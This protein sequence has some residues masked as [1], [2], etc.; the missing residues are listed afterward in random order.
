MSAEIVA[1]CLGRADDTPVGDAVAVP[2]PWNRVE[3]VL[4]SATARRLDELAGGS[5]LLRL[6][7]LTGAVAVCLRSYSGEPAPRVCVSAIRDRT[8]ETIDGRVVEVAQTVNGRERI[9]DLLARTRRLLAAGSDADRPAIFADDVHPDDAGEGV[10]V[11]L[12]HSVE[13]LSDVRGHLLV[14]WRRMPQRHALIAEYRV[15]RF[16]RASVLRFARHMRSALDAV[17]HDPR[18]VVDDVCIVDLHERARLDRWSTGSSTRA[19]REPVHSLMMRQAA[20]RPRTTAIVGEDGELTY[21]EMRG[22]V[23]ATAAL[24]RT[25]GARR[26]TPVGVCLSRGVNLPP[27]LFGVL[28][29]GAAYVPLDPAEPDERLRFMLGEAGVAVVIS[30]ARDHDRLAALAPVSVLNVDDIPCDTPANAPAVFRPVADDLAYILFTSGSTGRPKGAMNTHGG[31]SNRLEWMQHAYR[32]KPRDVVLHKTPTTFDVSLWELV[33]PFMVGARLVVAKPDG[34]RD[35]AYLA[36]L[37]QEQSVTVAH[38]VPSMLRAF[39]DEPRSAACVSLRRIIC[40]GESLGWSLQRDC[41]SRLTGA[42]LSNLYGPTEAAIDVT[43]HECQGPGERRPVPIGRPIWNTSLVVLDRHGR[44]APVGSTGDLFIGGRNVALGY[45]GRP[46][47][48]AARFVP[49]PLPG[50]SGVRLYRTGDLARFDDDGELLFL[51]RRDHQVKVRGHRIELEEIDRVL[52]RHDDVAQVATVIRQA[53]PLGP[54]LIAFVRRRSSAASDTADLTAFAAARLPAYMVPGRIVAVDALPMTATGKVDRSALASRE[55]SDNSQP[56]DAP[57]Y[58][59]PVEEILADIWR[60]VLGIAIGRDDNVFERGAHS[61]AAA[62]AAARIRRVFAVDLPLQALFSAPTIRQLAL[63]ISGG[64]IAGADPSRVTGPRP[65]PRRD[66][67]PLSDAQR[68]LWFLEQTG[69]AGAA[70]HLPGAFRIRGPLSTGALEKSYDAVARRHEILQTVFAISD[71]IPVQRVA[72]PPPSILPVVDLAALPPAR[73]LDDAMSIS[74]ADVR[75]PFDFFRVPAWRC[76]LLRLADDDHV[77]VVCVHHIL[78]DAWSLDVWRRELLAVYRSLQ[79]TE[80][81]PLPDLPLQYAHYAAWQQEGEGWSAEDLEWWRRQLDGLEKVSLPRDRSATGARTG[82]GDVVSLELPAPVVAAAQTLAGRENAT[83][84][85]VLLAAFA[86]VLH[87]YGGACDIGIGVAVANRHRPEVESLIGLFANTLVL[88]AT[89]RDGDDFQQLLARVRDTMLDAFDRGHVPFERVVDALGVGRELSRNPLFDVMF[90]LRRSSRGAGAG[91]EPLGFDPIPLASGG[92]KFDLEVHAIEQG[93]GTWTVAAEYATDVFNRDTVVRL[94][95][96]Y[97]LLLSA[98]VEHPDLR[99]GELPIMEA[100]ERQQVVAIGR[101]V[102]VARQEDTLDG[103]IWRLA[104][105]RPSEIAAV[106]TARS[107]T[108]GALID[109]AEHLAG[110]LAA[111]GIGRED[112]VGICVD[113]SIDMV[114]AILAVLRAGACYVPLEPDTPAPRL[115]RIAAEASIGAVVTVRRYDHLLA[116][117]APAVRRLRLDETPGHAPVARVAT[118]SQGSLAYV[119]FTSGSTGVP[120]GAANEHGAVVNR[121]LWMQEC[122][123][124]DARDAVLHKTPLGF[125]VSGWEI[126]LPLIAGARLVIAPPGAHREPEALTELMT[127]YGVTVV[128]FVPSML[129]AWLQG[130]GPPRCRSLRLVIASGEGLRTSTI[131]EFRRQS[132]AELHNLYGPTEAAIDVTHWPCVERPATAV[133]PIGRPIANVGV[134]VVDSAL[135]LQP[136]GAHGEVC[137]GGVAP[138]R[139]YVGRPDLTAERFVPDSVSGASGAR[140]YRTGDIGRTTGSG[141]IEYLGRADAQVKVHGVR[142]E[143]PEIEAVMRTHPAVA[144]SAVVLSDIGGRQQLVA[145]V[146][147]RDAVSVGELRRH[148]ATMLPATMVPTWFVCIDALPVTANGK[149][150][151]RSLPQPTVESTPMRRLPETAAERTV[152]EIWR[153]VL[154]REAGVDDNF[155][156]VGGDSIQALRVIAKAAERGLVLTV[157]DLFQH[158]TIADLATVSAA[159]AAGGERDV[160]DSGPCELLAA[161]HWFFAQELQQPELFCQAIALEASRAVAPDTVERALAAVSRRHAALRMSFACGEDGWHAAIDERDVPVPLAIVDVSS[162]PTSAHRL[163]ATRVAHDLQRSIR[164]ERAPLWRVGLVRGAGRDRLIWVTHHTISDGVSLA[165]LVEDFARA[166]DSLESGGHPWR[167]APGVSIRA[168]AAAARRAVAELDVDAE[169]RSWAAAGFDRIA[170]LPREGAGGPNVAE[171]VRHHRLR[172]TD[173]QIDAVVSS[174]RHDRVDRREVV[175]AA[176]AA[177]IGRMFGIRV[178]GIDIE[179]H[180]RDALE[181]LDASRTVGWFTTVAPVVIDVS[182][183]DAALASVRGAFERGTA[184]ARFFLLRYL[185]PDAHVRARV[186]RLVAPDIVFNDL[187]RWGGPSPESRFAVDVDAIEPLR[188]NPNRR[189]HL[190]EITSFAIDGVVVVDL[191]YSVNT[192]TPETMDLVAAELQRSLT[193]LSGVGANVARHFPLA[194][195]S[196]ASIARV[197]ARIPFVE[198]IHPLTPVQEG[199]LFHSL[200]D[201]SREAYWGVVATLW[202]RADRGALRK[203]VEHVRGR[204]PALRSRIV[205]EDVERPHQV[206]VTPGAIAWEELDWRDRSAEDQAASM[207][208]LLDAPAAPGSDGRDAM[209]WILV[210]LGVDRFYLV[211]AHHHALVDG[212]SVAT[213]GR[214]LLAAYGALI[215]G[216][217]PALPPA[218]P[219]RDYV[220]WRADRDR[221]RG[222]RFWRRRLEGCRPTLLTAGRVPDEGEGHAEENLTLGADASTALAELARA[223]RVT[224]STLVSAAWALVLAASTRATD[225]VFGQTVSG[226]PAGLQGSPDIV[227]MFINTVPCRIGVALGADVRAWLRTIFAEHAEVKQFE[228]LPLAQIGRTTGVRPGALFDSILVVENYPVLPDQTVSD[229]VPVTPVS[230]RTPNHYPFTVRVEPGAVV[231][232][233][234][235]FARRWFTSREA[236]RLLSAVRTVLTMFV[237]PSPIRVEAVMDRVAPFI[238]DEQSSGG[239]RSIPALEAVRPTP[240]DARQ[241]VGEIRP[242]MAGSSFPLLVQPITP[243]VQPAEWMA[244]ERERLDGLLLERGALLFRGFPIRTLEDFERFA[245]AFSDRLY[246]Q[247]GDLPRKAMTMAVYES[248]AYPADRWILFHNES[249]HLASW[250]SRIWFFCVEAARQGGETPIADCRRLCRVIDSSIIE[251]VR[252]LGFQYVRN[253]VDKLDVSWQQFFHTTDRAIVEQQCR[254][255]GTSFEW[256]GDGGLRTVR[257]AR[258]ITT[259][260]RTG[261]ELFFAQVQLHHPSCLDPAVRESIAAV[262]GA[263]QFPRDV[264]FGDG[265]V[266]DDDTMRRI[267]EAYEQS[268]FAFPWQ[269]GDVLLL[270]NMLMAHARRPFVGPRSC[271]VVLSDVISDAAV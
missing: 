103:L 120:K 115:E 99:L 234:A 118:S 74:R 132:Q 208:A 178:L 41:L 204:H 85:A 33:W 73:R 230:I 128:H 50:A 269:A 199:M 214:E 270:D 112:R 164:L 22:R 93:D 157:H 114:A 5:R 187:G 168:W 65:L 193:A 13:R 11:A 249:S 264:R 15:G 36:E 192:H 250:P 265:S 6:S 113:R 127:T 189:T 142:I 210:Q 174:A 240:L 26:G 137:I 24:L 221:E 260:P 245:R 216:D 138:A 72:G 81:E 40:S 146:V 201:S 211:W 4:S 152:A 76:L 267:G 18:R 147:P 84:F 222:E 16:E 82:V 218:R 185:H 184:A 122:F 163:A 104:A 124:L 79:H 2:L 77:L 223:E 194:R 46:D 67:A 167:S 100:L 96:S 200:G 229:G 129:D 166:C 182:S 17:V 87:R 207:A 225:V 255:T 150:D 175:L 183:E 239:A 188:P 181:G 141:V 39:L 55:W 68:R 172:L 52:E 233:R 107:I 75:R 261:E 80:A 220:V 66:D 7:T 59:G 86:C 89:V 203:A 257:R 236:V 254:E 169:L 180:G 28:C 148:A 219:F 162:I 19:P 144:Q 186:Q 10:V 57:V 58:Q 62:S 121:L 266:I 64:R 246:E 101:G 108:R 253:F 248:T 83:V 136:V 171:S 149:L 51:G 1:A 42:V 123:A 31:L 179:R 241:A 176:T 111:S 29:S 44:P 91:C 94:L 224:L 140:L 242:L 133:A 119:I 262:Y 155:F 145:Y 134:W 251:R 20:R 135:R 63:R 90:G 130:G 153:D 34:H 139:G 116:G 102:A 156:A 88:R 160:A 9:A 97:V 23:L 25:A 8:D 158:P 238:R 47:L 271:A 32:L 159:E 60:S 206:V 226:R 110:W 212:W 45:V 247:Y 131:G 191:T 143:L 232:L 53:G 105:E 14:T 263:E 117:L 252:A 49:S 151:R 30:A 217:V 48:T 228:E 92:A 259:H 98:A 161:Q 95:R 197:A 231:R 38:F 209:R 69:T 37:I 27:T 227:G 177:A 243:D 235:L 165:I 256:L 198:D 106:D 126:L 43:S 244:S 21:E 268:S 170:W 196:S 258:G 213:V 3:V 54:E 195:L 154:G 71:G 56:T 78:A 12:E 202:T 125:D 109:E 215:R 237:S 70:Y 190:L 61:L 173:A 205:W 35:P